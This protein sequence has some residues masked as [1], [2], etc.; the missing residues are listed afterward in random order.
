MISSMTGFARQESSGPFGALVCEI[1]SVNHRFLDASLRLPDNCRALESELRQQ[2]AQALR[3]GKVDCTLQL[4]AVQAGAQSLEVDPAALQ[5]VLARVSEIVAAQPAAAYVDA[6]DVLRWP[7]VLREEETDGEQLLAAVRALFGATLTELG[8]ARRREG[9]RLGALIEQRC[10]ALGELVAQVR[11]RMP[12]IQARV[13]SRLQERLA[14]LGGELNQDRIEQE[15]VLLLQR[16][17]VAEELDRLVGHIEE[18][19]R[20]MASPEPAGRRLDFLLQEF[21]REANTLSSKSQDL[22]TTR[23]AVE[24]KVLIEQMREQVQNLE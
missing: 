1:R 4:R 19:R 24:M 18:A 15:I 7:G 22:E 10:V 9:D 11:A 20:T 8:A 21:N 23:A 13:R 16:L 2:L 5:R 12:E 3:R 14:E 17:D 6:L